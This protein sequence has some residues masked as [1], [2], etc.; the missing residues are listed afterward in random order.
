MKKKEF[1]ACVNRIRN[2]EFGINIHI[3]KENRGILSDI[4]M[5]WQDR[6]LQ[7]HTE[8]LVTCIANKS[9]DWF[10]KCNGWLHAI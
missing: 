2:E 3:R 4:T 6:D 9:F 5:C 10:A 8:V 1:T 7:R